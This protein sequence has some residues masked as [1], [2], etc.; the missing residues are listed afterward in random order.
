MS[1]KH[2]FIGVDGGGSRCR[3]RLESD[4]GKLLASAE[5][6]PA[7]IM[8]SLETACKSIMDATEQAIKLSGQKMSS[9]QIVL[10]AG[11]AGA[12]I[13]S[14]KKAFLDQHLPFQKVQLISDLHAACAGAH[15]GE[16]GAVIVCGTGSSAT[17]YLDGQFTDYGGYGFPIGDKASGAWL[18]LQAIQFCLQAFDNLRPKEATFHAVC[19]HLNATSAEDIVRKCADFNSNNYAE[20]VLPLLPLFE[21][22]N[23]VVTGFINEGL[24]YIQRL[25]DE[26]LITEDMRLCLIG[27][28]TQ[29]YRPM[30]SNAVQKRIKDCQ[31]S[32]EQGAIL[33]AKQTGDFS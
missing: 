9:E 30:L 20:I 28:L 19:R 12:N 15:A 27:G 26:V 6:G 21:E 17:R 5:S 32:P 8:R 25:A 31:L 16:N 33:L 3:V 23:A 10:C 7:N 29:I 13:S 18:G 14:A 4:D 2:F 24:G 22:K 1:S 11:L